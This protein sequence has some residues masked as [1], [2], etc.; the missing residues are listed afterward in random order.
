MN[1]G[2]D[3]APLRYNIET[4][5][6]NLPYSVDTV[7]SELEQENW[8]S[9]SDDFSKENRHLVLDPKSTTLKNI[10]EFLT[11]DTVKKQVID[12]FYSNFPNIQNTWNGWTKEQMFERTVW[13]GF[14]VRDLPG[15]AMAKH[16][17]SRTNV[18]TAIIYLNKDADEKRTTRFFTD[19]NGSDELLIDN[20]FAKGVVSIN[21]SDTWHEAKNNTDSPRYTIILILLLLIDFYDP[22]IHSGLFNPPPKITL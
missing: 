12:S 14:F 22:V 5:S 3:I 2:I 1:F 20:D 10:K 19:K 4:I 8:K 15:Y 21:D 13:D 6:L 9:P 17:D 11:S 16:V 18:A 7:I